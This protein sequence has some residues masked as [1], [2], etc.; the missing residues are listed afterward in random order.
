MDA[1]QPVV[2]YVITTRDA[3]HEPTKLRGLVTPAA[4]CFALLQS[5]DAGVL[6]PAEV[7]TSVG[8]GE[9]I[10]GFRERGPSVP[11][12]PYPRPSVQLQSMHATEP[13]GDGAGKT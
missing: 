13:D 1:R 11:V 12:S 3:G 2:A 6:R 5:T 7:Y 8:S 4:G 9:I 10:M